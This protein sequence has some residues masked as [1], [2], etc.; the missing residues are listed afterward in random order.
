MKKYSTAYAGGAPKRQLRKPG[1]SR[2][3]DVSG[4]ELDDMDCLASDEHL[5]TDEGDTMSSL[6]E[7]G[8]DGQATRAKVAPWQLEDVVQFLSNDGKDDSEPVYLWRSQSETEKVRPTPMGSTKK[9]SSSSCDSTRERLVFC[10][11]CRCGKNDMHGEGQ[12]IQS[13]ISDL[14]VQPGHKFHC[15]YQPMPTPKILQEVPLK[16]TSIVF[17]IHIIGH[18]DSEGLYLVSSENSKKSGVKHVVCWKGKVADV[19]AAEFSSLFYQALNRNPSD[20]RK[21]FISDRCETTAA[22][23]RECR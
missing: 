7:H 12:K 2:G 17:G 23:K 8:R 13:I 9:P 3:A 11:Q 10:A 1:S 4:I 5:F 14:P 15:N 20:D 21:A 18:G 19:V 16:A 22:R 6:R